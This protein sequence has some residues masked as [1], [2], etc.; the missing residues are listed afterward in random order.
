MS[1]YLIAFIV[2]NYEIRKNY[3]GI[4]TDTRL[5][6]RILA[7][8]QFMNDLDLPLQWSEDILDEYEKYLNIK[9]DLPK[10]DQVGIPDFAAGAMENWG[11][12]T[13]A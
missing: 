3:E 7:N 11:L 1:T 4:I 5:S 2:S 8:P 13:Y 12:V 9:Y 6:H 10:I